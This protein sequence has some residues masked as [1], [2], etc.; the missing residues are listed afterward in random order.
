MKLSHLIN[1]LN[2]H[3]GNVNSQ[4]HCAG[5]LLNRYATANKLDGNG[6]DALAKTLNDRNVNPV[7]GTKWSK[8]TISKLTGYANAVDAADEKTQRLL[9]SIGVHKYVEAKRLVED[10]ALTWESVDKMNKEA[11]R[12]MKTPRA[13]NKRDKDAETVSISTFYK[14]AKAARDI[15]FALSK[16]EAFVPSPAE[17]AFVSALGAFLAKAGETGENRIDTAQTAN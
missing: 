8:E 3:A 11:V 16:L 17:E 12:K 4:H 13:K 6:L 1:G 9:I 10:G 7:L 14:H 2:T 5:N 15:F